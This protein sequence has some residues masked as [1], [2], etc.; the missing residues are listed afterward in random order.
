MTKQIVTGSQT[1]NKNTEPRSRSQPDIKLY[2]SRKNSTIEARAAALHPISTQQPD[3]SRPSI[4]PTSTDANS[5]RSDST[6]DAEG[7]KTEHQTKLGY[8]AK[9]V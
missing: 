5:A 9:G 4:T 6:I 7:Y 3:R 2:L 8:T 1:K